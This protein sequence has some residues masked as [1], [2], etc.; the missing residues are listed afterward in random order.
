MSEG[1]ELQAGTNLSQETQLRH[2]SAQHV[3]QQ[4]SNTFPA[5]KRTL[6]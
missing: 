5:L 2:E 1:I 3:L 6:Y 4:S